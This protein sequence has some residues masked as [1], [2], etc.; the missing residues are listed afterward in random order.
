MRFQSYFPI[1]LLIFVMKISSVISYTWPSCNND[2]IY[3]NGSPYSSNLNQVMNDLLRNIPQSSGFNTSSF[4]QT[5]NKVYGLLQ[6]IGNVSIKKCSDCARNSNNSFEEVCPNSIGGMILKDDCFLRY[7]NY[8][9]FSQLDNVP[10]YDWFKDDISANIDDFKATTSSLLYNLSNSA[11]NPAN[12]GFAMGSANYSKSNSVYGFVQCWRS[13]SIKDCKECLFRTRNLLEDC[14]SGKEG[15]QAMSKSC[16]V[17]FDISQFFDITQSSPLPTPPFPEPSP[18]I[19]EG[20]IQPKKKSLKILPIIFGAVGGLILVLITCLIAMRKRLRSAIFVRP[21]TQITHVKG[22]Y[23][24]FPQSGFLIH[25]QQHFLNSLE[26]MAEA[27]QN[28]HEN[29]KLGEGGFG[30]VYKGTTRDGKEIAVKK[31][32]CRSSQGNTEFMNEVK[33]MAN[34]DNRNLVKLLGCCIEGDER[35]L[36]YEYFPNKSLDTFI[37]DIE[38]CKQLDWEKR[39]NIIFG[40][41]RGL[42][43]LHEDSHL[44]IIH[45]DIKASNIMLDDRLK[46]KIADFGLARLFPGEKTLTQTQLVAGTYGYMAPE[47]V[48]G[49]QLSVKTDVYSFGV[50]LL[51]IVSGRKITHCNLSHQTEN[52]FDWAW[53]LYRGGDVLQMVESTIVESCQPEQLLRCIQV[54]LLCVQADATVRPDI[55]KVT[56]MISGDAVTLPSPIRPLIVNVSESQVLEGYTNTVASINQTSVTNIG[57]R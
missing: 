47:Y 36:V 27:T 55:W 9:F 38:K 2:S 14:C 26:E 20:P 30:P 18:P 57:P 56:V 37:F 48:M 11:Y 22:R 5:P 10:E 8:S 25:D 41:A 28:F 45:R 44:R 1:L 50:L 6:C 52:L 39:F 17:K 31:L 42:L 7:D 23:G 35:L 12:K 16:M 34:L 3:A 13:L 51:E 29:N 32:S 46:P 24:Y 43:Y 54:G 53:R 21:D 33:L 49:G 19:T 40:I 15:A 4:G